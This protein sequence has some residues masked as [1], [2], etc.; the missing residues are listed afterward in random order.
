MRSNVL[1][2][3]FYK[4]TVT[5]HAGCSMKIWIVLLSYKKKRELQL[6]LYGHSPP[7]VKN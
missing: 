7:F 5:S 1:Y 6:V 3:T 2:I 4:A